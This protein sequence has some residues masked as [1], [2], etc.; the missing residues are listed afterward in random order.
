MRDR[1][2]G[3]PRGGH[4]RLYW[5]L[6]DSNAWRCLNAADQRAYVA[7]LRNKRSTNNGDLS[8]AASVARNH[9]I[10]SQTT[11]AKC[12]RA[13]VAVGLVAVTRKGGCKPGGQ[14][15][16]TLYRV[17]D[18]PCYEVPAKFVQASKATNEWKAVRTLAQGRAMIRQA[19][20]EAK[21]EALREAAERKARKA[22]KGA[23]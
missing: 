22:S 23:A 3:D 16:P 11:L 14:R 12:L 21:A 19:E 20:A 18:E 13:L 7:L 15:L 17:T 6:I 8:L 1:P 9:G 4:V 10:R 5:D 2:K